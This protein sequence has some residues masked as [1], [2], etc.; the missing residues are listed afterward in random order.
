MHRAA[1]VRSFLAVIAFAFSSVSFAQ[2][3]TGYPPQPSYYTV[4]CNMEINPHS[5]ACHTWNFG[6]N[7]LFPLNPIE[8]KNQIEGEWKVLTYANPWTGNE[9]GEFVMLVDEH[10]P[11]IPVGVLNKDTQNLMGPLTIKGD[12]ITFNNWRGRKLKAN[13]ATVQIA[14]TY[15][16]KFAM[17]DGPNFQQSFVCRDFNRNN[18][19]HLICAWYLIRLYGYQYTWELRGY[20]GFLKEGSGSPSPVP[21]Q[22]P[23][24]PPYGY[25]PVPMPPTQ[26]NP[27]SQ[28]PPLPPPA[29]PVAL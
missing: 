20:F 22:P 2:Y 26:P 28:P 17:E 27:P 13:P 7:Y 21:P 24:Q 8:W 23:Q 29:P 19:H 12:K 25:E 9:G 14:D 18:K 1:V 15:T 5:Y 3:V 4:P 6:G 16:F 11:N 10:N